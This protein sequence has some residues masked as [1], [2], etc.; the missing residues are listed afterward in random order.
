MDLA[1]PDVRALHIRKTPDV[2]SVA[3]LLGITESAAL[4]IR[5]NFG[6]TV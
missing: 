4:A 2:P 6:W 1:T 5:P 3:L